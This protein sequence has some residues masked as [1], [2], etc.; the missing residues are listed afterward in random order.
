[1][2]ET[3]NNAK[4]R[5]PG[6]CWMAIASPLVVVVGLLVG[7]VFRFFL[8][9]I[10]WTK[11]IAVGVLLLSMGVGLGLGI[12]AIFRTFKSQR[13]LGGVT[14]GLWAVLG[15]GMAVLFFIE[16]F[17]PLPH[18]REYAIWS[19]GKAIMGTIS[20]GIR[21][22]AAEQGPDGQLPEDNDFVVL[23]FAPYD[24]DGTYF[25]QSTDKMFSYTVVSL[26]PL[27]FTVTAVNENLKPNTVTLDQNGAW[28]EKTE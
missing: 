1:M 13:R 9:G 12:L 19:E 5:K 4:G 10:P 15:V 26:Y 24:L 17:V 25:N 28:T 27:K 21:A 11:T 23:G 3:E 18:R 7:I 8:E 20:T 6:I 14:G 16:V 22:Y 2:N